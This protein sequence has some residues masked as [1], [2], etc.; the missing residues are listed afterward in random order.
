MG[1]DAPEIIAVKCLPERLADD[2]ALRQILLQEAR[3]AMLLRHPNIVHVFDA[4]ESRGQAYIAME[5][6]HGLDLAR[7]R[8]QME[9]ADERLPPAVIA[10]V[11]GQV[12][13]GLDYAHNLVHDAELISLVHRD[14]SPHN[15]MLSVDGEVKLTDFGV[16]RLSSEDTSGTHVKG[17]A[18]YMPPE[19]LRGESRSPTVDLFAAGAVLHELLDGSVFRGE[20]IDDA[21]LLGMA[22]D[23][24]VPAPKRPH[25]I[26]RQLERLRRG[27]LAPDPRQRIRSADQ[28]LALLQDWKPYRDTRAEVAQIV[29]RYLE[30]QSGLPHQP[31][32]T[33]LAHQATFL[34]TN[35]IQVERSDDFLSLDGL[36][37]ESMLSEPM[38]T[39]MS[40]PTQARALAPEHEFALRE[41]TARPATGGHR[42]VEQLAASTLELD[43]PNAE[44][45]SFAR[46]VATSPNPIVPRRRLATLLKILGVIA[47]LG[48]AGFGVVTLIDVIDARDRDSLDPTPAPGD[49]A[50]RKARV[51]G[52][53][54]PAHAGFRHHRMDKLATDDI[55]Y[56]YVAAPRNPSDLL[57]ALAAGEAEFALT[58]LDQLLLAHKHGAARPT[59]KI[60]AVV[61]V[62]FGADALV[63]DSLE[64]PTLR[65]LDDLAKLGRKLEPRPLLAYADG[66][67]SAY[68]E[69]HLVT[70][71]SALAL[72]PSTLQRATTYANTQAVY[73]ALTAEADPAA[74]IVAAILSEPWL[75]KAADAG[76][77]IAA[78]T[79]DLPHAMITVL[80][81]SER[82]LENDPQLVD[83]VVARYYEVVGGQ[84]IE[85]EEGEALIQQVAK[86]SGLTA[87]EATQSLL[88]LCRFDAVGAL[89]WLRSSG[90]EPALIAAAIEATWIT[91][92]QA[93]RVNGPVNG[94]AAPSLASLIDAS[95]L[96]AAAAGQPKIGPADNC[97]IEP[98]PL[99]TAKTL[100]SQPLGA[101]ELPG[102]ATPWFVAKGTALSADQAQ[103]VPALAARLRRF[104][105]A[106]VRAV[107]TGFG[108]TGGGKALGQ[109]RARALVEAL[110][111]A[112]VELSLDPRGAPTSAGVPATLLR[113]SLLRIG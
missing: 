105:P 4:G 82:V 7:L 101:L 97:V 102:P 62:S 30:R 27:L 24:T 33:G 107:I 54:L 92:S 47:G 16:A 96:V 46:H 67:P 98:M 25:E 10:Y 29:M 94:L 40:M 36:A 86:D 8:K 43:L 78:S 28:A 112:G 64:H 87:A 71:L 90:D 73:E 42:S 77:T 68:L 113:I 76:M 109:A 13:T 104:N 63:L 72:D 88:G 21:R 11:I 79:R 2:P 56:E 51:L 45:P 65:S 32:A 50:F 6:V 85:P 48:L 81:A 58:R 18:R 103:L 5:F 95:A 41:D 37:D 17:K 75:S 12:L 35:Q 39:P 20:A 108:D 1:T 31:T 9:Q 80:L 106:T 49:S 55:L 89:P 110:Q 111:A 60:V 15:V 19:Q 57:A 66:T 14:I 61:G 70:L 69:Q 3:L 53:N 91:L 44:K 23:G 99:A 22:V 74:P 59:A 83:A 38:S 52:D 84:Q 26:P 34:H 93:D 100:T